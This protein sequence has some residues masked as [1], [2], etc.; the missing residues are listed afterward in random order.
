M[1]EIK[2]RAW[3]KQ[4]KKWVD[5]EI[6]CKWA[7]YSLE[8]PSSIAHEITQFTG[9]KD[10]QGKEIYEGDICKQP[11]NNSLVDGEVKEWV[12]GDIRYD[13][14]GFSLMEGDYIHHCIKWT[15]EVI[16]NIHENP[17]LLK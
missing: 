11:E 8:N 6:V 13:H 14:D 1:R 7:I 4:F 16:G 3:D 9:L 5:P 15:G 10:K 17:E 12:T 2:F